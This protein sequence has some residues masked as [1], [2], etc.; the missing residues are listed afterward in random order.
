MNGRRLFRDVAVYG[1]GDVATSVV[2]F[3][4]IPVYTRVLTPADYG[5]FALLLTIEA[6]TK[7]LLRWGVDAA[8]MRLYYDCDNQEAKQT[9]ASTIWGFLFAVNAP[10][11]AGAWLLAPWLGEAMFGTGA[12]T[13]TLRAFF[14][15]TFVIG[16]F[17]IPFH[18]YRIAGRTTSFAALTFFRAAGTVALRLILVLVWDLGV[19]GL[20]LADLA[21]TAIVGVILLPRFAELARPRFSW[22][23][24]R[25]ALRVG[26]PRVPHGVALQTT[27]LSDRWILNAFLSPDRVGIYSIGAAF[28]LSVKLFLSAFDTAWAPFA[29]EAMKRPEAKALYSRVTTYVAALLVL[30]ATVLSAV[31]DDLVELMTDAAFHEAGQIVPWVALGV[32]FQGMFQLTAVGLNITKR[33]SRLPI[34]TFAGTFVSIG[35]NLLLVPRYGMIAAAWTSALSYAVVAALGFML[36][37]RVYRIEYDRARLAIVAIAGLAGYGFAWLLTP[38]GWPA[39]ARVASRGVL[40]ASAYLTVLVVTGVIARDELRRLANLRRM[41]PRSRPAPRDEVAVDAETT[42]ASLIPEPEVVER[43]KVE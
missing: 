17:F 1:V 39:L 32:V 28:G 34:A 20:V 10:I 35:A 6:G 26:L 12:Y 23:V 8:F 19:F 11:L 33:T 21:L 7:I 5:V 16:F 43:R 36:S 15:N 41:L 22:A 37:Q 29:F 2:S 18:L 30:L 27:A 42:T 38:D 4:L 25:D 40:A 9:L 3:L 13:I 14:L 24:L 31:A